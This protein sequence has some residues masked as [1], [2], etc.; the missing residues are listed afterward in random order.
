MDESG[1]LGFNKKKNNSKY[2]VITFLFTN[3]RK[4]IEKL[5]K[6]N[7]AKLNNKLK[8]KINCLHAAKE[9]PVMRRRILTDLS[10]KDCDV[11]V[12]CLNKEKVYSNLQDKKSVL[13]NYVTNIL[14]DRVFS[15]KLIDIEKKI[16]L[17]ASRRE[18]N[19][20]LNENFKQ[21]LKNQILNKHGK[22]IS[23]D[24]VPPHRDKL[25]QAVDFA[26]W[27]IFKKYEHNDNSYYDYFKKI[28]I[29][30]NKLFF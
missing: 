15:K 22:E 18:T 5:I 28:I 27:A 2:F 13:Y 21:Y 3:D 19:K 8:R 24:I 17:V 23:V 30:E 9:K 7:H 12:I 20:F 1:D 4:G 6:K 16:N 11:M 14:L 29:E 10:K 25:L 26:S